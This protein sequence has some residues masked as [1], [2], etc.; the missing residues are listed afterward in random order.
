MNNRRIFSLMYAILSFVSIRTSAMELDTE[1]RHEPIVAPSTGHLT[2]VDRQT[3]DIGAAKAILELLEQELAFI[4]NNYTKT[5]ALFSIEDNVSLGSSNYFAFHEIKESLKEAYLLFENYMRIYEPHTVPLTTEEDITQLE[6]IKN[7]SWI[8]NATPNTPYADGTTAIQIA[9]TEMDSLVNSRLEHLQKFEQAIDRLHTFLQ[10]LISQD[11]HNGS[12]MPLENSDRNLVLEIDAFFLCIKENLIK[13]HKSLTETATNL[14]SLERNIREIEATLNSII[15]AEKKIQAENNS[16]QTGWGLARLF[17]S[18]ISPQATYYSPENKKQALLKAQESLAAM[19]NQLEEAKECF[20]TI[21]DVE[22]A[23]IQS[24]KTLRTVLNSNGN[25]Q[26]QLYNQRHVEDNLLKDIALSGLR[27]EIIHRTLNSHSLGRAARSILSYIYPP[28]Q[29]PEEQPDNNLQ[30]IPAQQ[31]RYPTAGKILYGTR[32]FVKAAFTTKTQTQQP[33]FLS[34]REQITQIAPELPSLLSHGNPADEMRQPLDERYTHW[35]IDAKNPDYLLYDIA[36]RTRFN[37][38]RFTYLIKKSIYEAETLHGLLPYRKTEADQ[39]PTQLYQDIASRQQNHLIPVPVAKIAQAVQAQ[40]DAIHQALCQMVI[41]TVDQLPFYNK[42]DPKAQQV[43]NRT[44]LQTLATSLPPYSA[45]VQSIIKMT[46]EA[47][48]TGRP[49]TAQGLT[50]SIIETIRDKQKN[51]EEIAGKIEQAIVQLVVDYQNAGIVQAIKTCKDTTDISQQN[52][53]HIINKTITDYAIYE[54]EKILPATREALERVKDAETAADIIQATGTI[55]KILM[56]QL[57]HE[58]QI[59]QEVTPYIARYQDNLIGH[60]EPTINAAISE[61]LTIF[62]SDAGIIIQA[63]DSAVNQALTRT[64]QQIIEQAIDKVT[65]QEIDQANNPAIAE[66]IASSINAAARCVNVLDVV[67]DSVQIINQKLNLAADRVNASTVA[68]GINNAIET[69]I[70]DLIT[71]QPVATTPTRDVLYE[72][73][74]RIGCQAEIQI[75]NRITEPAINQALEVILEQ[76]TNQTAARTIQAAVERVSARAGVRTVTQAIIEAG[77]LANSEDFAGAVNKAIIRAVSETQAES[78]AQA[79]NKKITER[80]AFQDPFPN[81]HLDCSRLA[82][83]IHE[84]VTALLEGQKELVHADDLK[85]IIQ[86]VAQDPVQKVLQLPRGHEEQPGERYTQIMQTLAN[87]AIPLKHPWLLLNAPPQAAR[88]FENILRVAHTHDDPLPPEKQ[89]EQTMAQ[90]DDTST[91]LGDFAWK[92]LKKVCHWP[93]YQATKIATSA[94]RTCSDYIKKG[95]SIVTEPFIGRRPVIVAQ[96]AITTLRNNWT[97]ILQNWKI[98]NAKTIRWLLLQTRANCIVKLFEQQMR[99]GHPISEHMTIIQ[100]AITNHELEGIVKPALAI[101]AHNNESIRD[102]AHRY[103]YIQQ[104]QPIVTVNPETHD[105]IEQTATI[106]DM[107]LREL[108]NKAE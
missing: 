104:I 54:P 79:I 103:R 12:Q 35:L 55:R 23:S 70:R 32:D 9:T 107:R 26:F 102:F 90:H 44:I 57:K 28:E 105:L 6:K 25:P 31:P 88:L 13:S 68:T 63:V 85:T 81:M 96:R 93:A 22:L 83:S 30:R 33:Y 62:S 76:A 1:P 67:L 72:Q 21:N 108:F 4:H 41:S 58:P 39:D 17:A 10:N 7:G 89:T 74:R 19:L 42:L 20:R 3:G 61:I 29:T 106:K 49:I 84:K 53:D 97:Q 101:V 37:T 40:L 56:E 66:K 34:L 92:S 100:Q 73:A 5:L 60:I 99:N 64:Q 51:P 98:S 94:A 69:A 14:R 65:L 50:Q 43:V 18:S 77:T 91:S 75:R 47:L 95:F 87:E 8:K 2:E 71:S 15:T 45:I 78:I 48:E 86:S 80:L 82:R 59:A 36:A 27:S 11:I 24:I 38:G 46:N 16:P 52:I